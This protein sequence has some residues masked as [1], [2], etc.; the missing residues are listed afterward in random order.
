VISIDQNCIKISEIEKK[1][2]DYC[3]NLGCEMLKTMLESI[4]D[5][6]MIERDRTKYR[7]KG[8]SKT[9]LKTIMGEVEYERVIYACKTDDNKTYHVH[10]LD[11]LLGFKNVGFISE[12]LAEKIAEQTCEM[13]YRKA[14]KAVSEMTGQT[15]SHTGVWN[16]TQALGQKINEQE[17]N[18]AKLAKSNNSSGCEISKLLFEEQDGVWLNLQGKDRKNHGCKKEMKI[19]IAY[20]GARKTGKK[21]Y[22]LVGKVACAN[23]EESNKFY[24]RKE[25]VI[26]A[27][28]NLDE[29]EMRVLNGDGASWIKRSVADVNVHYQLDTFHRNKA[30]TTYVKDEEAQK[31]IRKLLYTKEISLMF[32]VIEAYSNSTSDEKEK[33]NFLQ[34]LTYFQNNKDGLIAYHRRGL[35]LPPPP[36]GL[37][38]RRCG[39]MESNVFSIIGRRM[40]RN[41]TN[42]SIKGGNNL[43]GLLTLKSCGKLNDT[44]RNFVHTV[45]PEKYEE[46]VQTI[47]SAG[48]VQKSVG[49]GYN[50]MK[51]ASFSNTPPWLR[52]ISAFKSICE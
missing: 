17:Q 8:K 4:D 16:V 24:A 15:I 6:I 9:V 50:G 14:A 21:R 42:W 27:V 19:G 20:K 38:Y 23:F 34:L 44:L 7:H 13:A 37:E 32:E 48:R 47:L 33:E 49:M 52:N 31:L 35:D 12:L 39:A 5:N 51:Q 28:Y 46:Q 2:Y 41:R 22:N 3:K 10:L 1:I 26:G 30:I 36:D 43:A 45:L 11:E 18:A 29:I 25:G 40:K